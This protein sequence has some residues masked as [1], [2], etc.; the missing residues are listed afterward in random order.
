MYDTL[1]DTLK[2][3]K[4]EVTEV[5]YSTSYPADSGEDYIVNGEQLTLECVF[6]GALGTLSWWT[7]RDGSQLIFSGSPGNANILDTVYKSRIDEQN[8]V[9]TSASHQLVITV[10]KHQDDE[11]EFKCSV[12]PP[13]IPFGSDK[14]RPLGEV[15]GEQCKRII[16]ACITCFKNFIN[17][18]Q[19][20]PFLFVILRKIIAMPL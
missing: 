18:I 11:Q 4:T 8:S 1:T 14:R 12:A 10:S 16:T 2:H 3:C 17:L 6:T 9:F 20:I 5:S 15:L 13:G 7:E 19:S